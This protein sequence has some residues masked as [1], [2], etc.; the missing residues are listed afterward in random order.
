[1]LWL[2][3]VAG[4]CYDIIFRSFVRSPSPSLSRIAFSYIMGYTPSMESPDMRIQIPAICI[5]FPLVQ[6]PDSDSSDLHALAAGAGFS[7]GIAAGLEAPA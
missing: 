4:T 3:G 7:R 6:L 5:L 2:C 1:M